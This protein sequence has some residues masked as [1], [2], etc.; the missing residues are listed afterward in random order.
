MFARIM[1]T[2]TLVL[3]VGTLAAFTA[4]AWLEDEKWGYTGVLGIIAIIVAGGIT[5]AA[6]EAE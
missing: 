6:Y 2:V 1:A 4:G 5:G 3:I